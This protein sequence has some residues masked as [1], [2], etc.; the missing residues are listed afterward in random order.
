MTKSL[1]NSQSGYSCFDEVFQVLMSAY[2]CCEPTHQRG[3]TLKR[4]K[5]KVNTG[6]L[7]TLACWSKD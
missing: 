4:R 6:Q 7:I 3:L 5:A 1:N 2:P